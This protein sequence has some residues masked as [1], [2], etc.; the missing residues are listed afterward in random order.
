[1]TNTF[2]GTPGPWEWASYGLVSG[3]GRLVVTAE[4][5]REQDEWTSDPAEVVVSDEDANLIEAAPDLLE[6]AL[7]VPGDSAH[8]N[9]WDEWRARND[10]A[11]AKALGKTA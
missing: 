8:I 6:V 2:R 11:I 4:N 9:E 10:A 5:G 3:D 7:S 1:M